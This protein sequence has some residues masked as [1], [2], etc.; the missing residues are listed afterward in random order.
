MADRVREKVRDH[1]P[2]LKALYDKHFP[3]ARANADRYWAEREAKGDAVTP[4][5]RQFIPTFLWPEEYRKFIQAR[6][7]SRSGH[8]KRLKRRQSDI[9]RELLAMQV[10]DDRTKELLAELGVEDGD[11]ATAMNRAVLLRALSGD[12]EAVRYIRDTIGEKPR[13]GLD[14]SVSEKPVSE[15]NLAEL[16]DEQLL[17]L[18]GNAVDTPALPSFDGDEE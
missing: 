7:G 1:D 4:Q 13:E 12:V 14:F 5:M 3:E 6:G 16:T 17:A 9:L 10:Q 11:F 18:A 15:M 8:N 2:E